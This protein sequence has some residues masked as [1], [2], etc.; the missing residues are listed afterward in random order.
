[1]KEATEAN[2]DGLV[3]PTHNYAGLALGNMASFSNKKEISHPKQAALQGLNKMK[4][5]ADMG[6]TQGVLAPQHRP[7]VPTLRRIG[8]SGKDDGEII[9]QAAKKAPQILA[10]CT[11]A[12]S[13]WTANAATISPS[14]DT[15]DGKIHITPAN[16]NNRFH[17]SIEH[18]TTGRIL[19]ATFANEDYFTHHLALPEHEIFGDEGAAN[20]TRLCPTYGSSGL[21]IFA[22]GADGEERNQPRPKKFPARQSRQASEAIARLHSLSPKQTIFAQQ[23]PEVIDQGVFHNDVIAVGNLNCFLYHEQAFLNEDQWIHQVQDFFQD[24]PHF[25]IKV[26][27]HQVSVSSAINSYL[28]NSQLLSVGPGKMALVVPEECH[29]ST[30]VWQY[31][32]ELTSASDNP[33]NEIKVID[34]KQS[35]KN[36]GGPAC[37]RL[38]VVL[39]QD[40][41]A[42]VNPAT[43]LNKSLYNKLL[44]WINKHYRDQISSDDLAD[45]SLHRESQVALDELSQI[46]NLGSIYDFQKN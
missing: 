25:L 5:L 28:F 20:H 4:T 42:A 16:L 1:M 13:M 17:R 41:L 15:A 10:N 2:F 43:L 37:L 30:E 8:F 26:P 23:N 31:L 29:Q 33:I 19:K 14:A 40:E 36:G 6:F 9:R 32:K 27:T 11:S 22:F 34:V 12:S 18:L 44:T 39:N 3:G 35:M 38:R 21:E 7:D 45:P 46:L 24:Q